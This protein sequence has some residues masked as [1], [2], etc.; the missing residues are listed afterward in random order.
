MLAF[1]PFFLCLFIYVQTHVAPSSPRSEPTAAAKG[2]YISFSPIRRLHIALPR[3]LD[4]DTRKLPTRMCLLRL[5]SKM[6]AGS[7]GVTEDHLRRHPI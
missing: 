5:H 1:H 4:V 2:L 3:H 6:H 7:F